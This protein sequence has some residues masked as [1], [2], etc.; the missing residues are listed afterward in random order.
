MSDGLVLF[1][2]ALFYAAYVSGKWYGNYR[3]EKW[4]EKRDKEAHEQYLKSCEEDHKKGIYCGVIA[5]PLS[6]TPIKDRNS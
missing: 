1:I 4:Q 3:Y 6:H 2:L 5:W